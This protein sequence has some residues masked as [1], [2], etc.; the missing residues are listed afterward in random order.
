[1]SKPNVLMSI[2]PAFANLIVDGYKTIELRRKFPVDF[3]SKCIIYSSSPTQAIIGEC[4]IKKVEKLT[5]KEL[6]KNY[7][8]ES[9][10]GWEQFEKYF[11]GCE[12]GYALILSSAK[13]YQEPIKLNEKISSGRPPQSY[14][15]L[16]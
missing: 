13:R 6:W 2:K 11:E 16:N 4:I 5:I 15:Y 9:M 14:C 8:E 12:H 7:S 1:M 3:S 10:I